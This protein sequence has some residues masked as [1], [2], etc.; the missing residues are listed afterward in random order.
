M[1]EGIVWHT[2]YHITYE[3]AD[4]LADSLLDVMQQVDDNL[5]A[6]N[7]ASAV[8]RL[9]EAD[10]VRAVPML[11]DV[12]RCS[13]RVWK[14]SGGYFDPSAAP[15][16][17]AY[18]FGAKKGEMP[19]SA[20][21]KRMLTLV[22]MNKIVERNG[23]IV[24]AETGMEVNFSALAKGYGC[25]C[26][27]RALAEQGCRNY[28]VEIGGEIVAAGRS[29]RGGKWRI[30]VD[31][32]IE[33]SETEVHASQL[34]IEVTDCAVATSGNYRNYRDT[35]GKRIGHIVNPTTGMPA[36]S[37]VV[38]A[39]IVADDC[40][41][42]DA[43]ATACMAMPEAEAVAMIERLQLRAFLILRDGS[44]Y[45]TPSFKSLVVE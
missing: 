30:S 17:N 9:N 35:G 10:S 14:E 36:E 8:S 32:P 3:S 7:R 21:V 12:V 4:D 26:V 1:M 25:D 38:S 16:I 40:M 33:N 41:S 29:P 23:W 43:Y 20:D 34:I 11:A 18:G 42:A 19:D 15:L 6:F 13:R 44:V 24:K 45:M 27:A 5:S 31:R 28:M 2:S 37:E 39:T 22:G